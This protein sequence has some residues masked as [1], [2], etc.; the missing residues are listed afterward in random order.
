MNIFLSCL[1]A[2]LYRLGGASPAD[3]PYMSKWL[4]KGYTRVI[5]V[6][7]I[8]I[9][10][11]LNN[12]HWTILP[13][14][15][16]LAIAVNSYHKWLNP[17]FK[18]PAT[19]CFWFNYLAHGF[20]ISLADLPYIWHYGLWLPFIYRTSILSLGIMLWSLIWKNVNIEE[21]GRGYLIIQSL[22]ILK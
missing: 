17:L 13:S 9:L 4:V 20:F 16:L 12:W 5:G 11:Y 15:L 19:D 14:T 8:Y 1:N 18:K 3:F 6:C 7:L 22:S 10:Y 21:G 2:I